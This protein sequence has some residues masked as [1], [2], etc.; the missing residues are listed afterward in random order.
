MDVYFADEANVGNVRQLFERFAG[1]VYLGPGF[2]V[3]R[4]AA[5]DEP[6]TVLYRVV[7]WGTWI[8]YGS[9]MPQ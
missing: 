1:P 4:A 7:V 2:E 8:I 5:H 3:R 6:G 9:V